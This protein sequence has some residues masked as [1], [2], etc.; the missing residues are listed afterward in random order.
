MLFYILFML[1][2]NFMLVEM[3][4]NSVFILEMI[5]KVYF[6]IYYFVDVFKIGSIVLFLVFIVILIIL[7]FMFVILFVK[8]FKD[9]NVKMSEGYKLKNYEFKG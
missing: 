3:L 2:F 8:K 7:F 4:K 9:I 6:F 1:R 5:R